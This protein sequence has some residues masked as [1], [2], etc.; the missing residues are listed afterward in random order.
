MAY[1]AI[2]SDVESAVTVDGDI[3]VSGAIRTANA[4]VNKLEAADT[5]SLL[6]QELLTQIE[7]YLACHF[8]ALRDPQYRQKKTGDASA[9][10]QTGEPGQGFLATDWGAQAVAMDV[11]GYLSRINSGSPR[12]T[13]AWLGKPPSEQTAYEDRD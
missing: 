7:I 1:R 4:V 12:A 3:P 9:T 2:E 11:T 8:Y 6:S 13:V 5:G 10:F